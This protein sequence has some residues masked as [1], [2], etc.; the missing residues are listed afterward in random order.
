VR[1]G[2]VKP[3]IEI[4]EQPS[5]TVPS[6]TPPPATVMI[7][8]DSGMHDLAPALGAAFAGAGTRKVIDASSPGFGLSVAEADWRDVWRD[9][10]TTH[11]P[12][13]VIAMLGGWDL[14]YLAAHG[15][16]GYAALVDEAV[17][18]LTAQGARIEWLAM[19]PGGATPG[20]EVDPVYAALPG[21]HP[22]TVDYF[23][24]EAVLRAPDGTYPRQIPGADGKMLLVRKP[25][26]W[27]LCPEGAALTT[28]SVL[29]HLV[30]IGW[31]PPTGD[32]WIGGQWRDSPRYDDPKGACR[33]AA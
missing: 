9:L 15:A 27:H 2:D 1:V 32:A 13:L 5:V 22:G 8:G 17:G 11:D 20:R 3:Q 19:L 29:D 24:P 30:A 7:V 21:S 26:A 6:T 12:D 16:D 23:D 4:T 31:A 14:K 25:D 10:V 33:V 28:Q 18:V